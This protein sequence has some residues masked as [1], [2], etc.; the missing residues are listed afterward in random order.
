MS[1]VWVSWIPR[2]HPTPL[3]NKSNVA[4]K[5]ISVNDDIVF[6]ILM[7]YNPPLPYFSCARE[8]SANPRTTD[9]EPLNYGVDE[10]LMDELVD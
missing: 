1:L 8:R 10:A 4:L 6:E 2:E 7:M 9:W 5:I 3:K